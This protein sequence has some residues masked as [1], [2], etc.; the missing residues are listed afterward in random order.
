MICKAN[1]PSG[2]DQVFLA[3]LP[4]IETIAERAF[5]HQ[6]HELRDELRAEVVA[7]AFVAFRRLVEVGKVSLA[8]PSPLARYAIAQVRD[9]RS[10]SG[11]VNSRD[12]LSFACRR[13]DRVCVES[14]SNRTGVAL[15]ALADGKRTP[16]ADRV[17]FRLDFGA[18]FNNLSERC[19]ALVVFLAVGNSPSAAA[20]R[21]KI[22]R[23]RISQLRCALGVAWQ[24]YQSH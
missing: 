17:A 18:W 24:E 10:V 15:D 4:Q 13:R 19:K 22:S 7:L 5:R 21:W 16:L 3:M 11:P 6:A 9:G 12:V 2:Y 23:G 1:D 20:R 8:F 14:L